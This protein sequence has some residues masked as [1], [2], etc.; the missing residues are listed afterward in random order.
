MFASAITVTVHR[1]ARDA[2]GDLV[3]TATHTIDRCALLRH[4]TNEDRDA[5]DQITETVTLAVPAGADITATDEVTL[6][7]GTRWH[8]DGRPHRLHSPLTGW[9]PATAVALRR[10]TG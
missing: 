7:D 3:D 9:E 1:T 8:V 10:V 4:S 2:F 5:R 6:P